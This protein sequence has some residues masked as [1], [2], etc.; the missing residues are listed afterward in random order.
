MIMKKLTP[1]K[2]WLLGTRQRFSHLDVPAFSGMS[3]VSRTQPISTFHHGDLHLLPTPT[4]NATISLGD[5]LRGDCIPASTGTESLS[6]FFRYLAS[7]LRLELYNSYFIHRAVP[8]ARCLYP[9]RCLLLCRNDKKIMLWRYMP[10]YHGMICQDELKQWPDYYSQCNM[11]LVCIADVWRIADKYGDY[12]VFP[13]VLEAGMLRGQACQL[14]AM[15]GWKTLPGKPL[16]EFYVKVSRL[17]L[18]MFSLGFDAP[19]IPLKLLPNVKVAYADWSISYGGYDRYPLLVEISEA[20]SKGNECERGY[21]P[22][23]PD[24]MS[25]ITEMKVARVDMLELMRQ[26][27]SGNDVNGFS[28]KLVMLGSGFLQDFIRIYMGLS[29]RRDVPNDETKLAVVIAWL[30]SSGPICGVYGLDGCLLS[31]ASP[32]PVFRAALPD[33]AYRYNISGFVMSIIICMQ[34]DLLDAETMGLRDVHLAAGAIAQDMC[35]AASGFGLFSRPLRMLREEV[36]ESGLALPGKLIYQL[37]MGFNR[38][39]LYKMDLL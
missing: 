27:N 16:S 2:I 22:W 20:F 32:L 5:Y 9:L 25:N 1:E 39:P 26:R 31:A 12:S 29:M 8:S 7:P 34:P 28:P 33:P 4:I 30:H 37:M 15:L 36:L 21:V 11:I 13:C 14:A 24:T 3:A 17:E 19:T 35:L 6:L 23:Q 18:P 10:D 38:N